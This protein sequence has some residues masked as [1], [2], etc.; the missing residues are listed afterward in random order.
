MKIYLF[1]T[2]IMERTNK[3]LDYLGNHR[4]GLCQNLERNVNHVYTI[5]S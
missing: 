2:K 4:Y 3:L 5:A 1:I